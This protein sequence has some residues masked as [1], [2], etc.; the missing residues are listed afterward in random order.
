MR[1]IHRVINEYLVLRSRWKSLNSWK[2]GEFAREGASA[3]GAGAGP[4][5]AAPD[6]SVTWHLGGKPVPA[7]REEPILMVSLMEK[8][9]RGK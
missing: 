8:K 7:S 3:D 1:E 2:P 6:S 4:G 9:A 5:A